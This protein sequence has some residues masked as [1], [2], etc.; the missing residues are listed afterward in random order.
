MYNKIDSVMI[1]RLQEIVGAEYV[2]TDHE[3]L[4]PYTHD[5]TPELFG[6]PEVVVKP[7]NTQEISDILVAANQW[8]VPVV[9]RG[10]GQGLSGGCVPTEGGIVLSVER[11]NRILEIDHKNLMVTVEPAVITGDLHRAVEE[12]GLFYPPDPAS[13]DSCHIGGN[14][15]ESAGGPRAVKFG[16]TK[17]YVMGM[18]V[19]LPTGEIVSWGGKLVKD[20][21][22]FNF[23][24]LL[25]GSEGILGIV[26][27]IILR[28]LPLPKAQIDLL[29]PFDSMQAAADTVAA[30]I[31]QALVPTTIEFMEREAVQASERLLKKEIPFSEAEA[32][33]LISLTGAREED[34]ENDLDIVGEICLD[35]GAL[36]VLVAQ[37]RPTRER[38]WEA[39][40]MILEA[41]NHAS[42]VNHT[43]DVA[44]PRSEI[45][46]LLEGIHALNDRVGIKAIC[47]G[48][49]GDG[50]VHVNY[51]QLDLTDDEWHQRLEQAQDALY[52][53]SLSLGGT[54][55]G[56]H[57]V[58]YT[59]RRYLIDS[60]GQP[61]VD[62]MRRVKVAF[63]PNNILNPG[64]VLPPVA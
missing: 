40:R 14:I 18:E 49:A 1:A 23:S 4:D 50:N 19:V 20:V 29:A 42:P 61:T 41:L 53:L 57:G 35:H 30:I 56:E 16:T 13:L 37:D 21:A 28:L 2:I 33:L 64:K 31:A 15:A 3:R 47:F 17:D 8:L 62:L 25:V 27:K 5:E 32:Q 52:A 39:R 63:D 44:V 55:T 34:L 9:P 46:A 11:M 54:I 10:G 26:T 7:A 38:L 58:G 51:M 60:L 12:E 45:P 59:R 43:E 48:H 24:Q 36:D 22:G 6:A